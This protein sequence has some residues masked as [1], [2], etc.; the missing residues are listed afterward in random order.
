VK[1]TT[2][3]ARQLGFEVS[4]V[5]DGCRG[6]ELAP[7]DCDKAIAEMRTAGASIVRSDAV[8]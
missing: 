3:D 2:L 8:T 4:L 7:G 5:I 1:F 6:V